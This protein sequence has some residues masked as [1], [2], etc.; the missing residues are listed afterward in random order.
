[1]TTKKC[2]R[3]GHEWKNQVEIP[4]VCPRCKSYRWDEIIKKPKPS[5]EK[6]A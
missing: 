6:E 1:M 4:V 5:T 3:C 2:L